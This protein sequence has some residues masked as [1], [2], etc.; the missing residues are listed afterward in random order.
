MPLPSPYVYP[1]FPLQETIINPLDGAPLAGGSVGFYSDPQFTILKPIYQQTQTPNGPTYSVLQNPLTLDGIGSYQDESGTEIIPF[2][3]P[4]SEGTPSD[5]TPQGEVELYF[6]QVL[7]SSGSLVF[8]RENWPPN[9]PNFASATSTETPQSQNLLVNSQFSEVLFPTS[10]PYAFSLSGTNT[11]TQIAPGWALKT[12]GAGTVTVSQNAL[13]LQTPSGAP[14]SLTLNVGSGITSIT[15]FQRVY[16]SPRLANAAYLAG[17]FEAASNSGSLVPLSFNYI[18]SSTSSTQVSIIPSMSTASDGSYGVFVDGSNVLSTPNNPDAPNGF[19]SGYVDFSITIPAL[20]NISITSVQVLSV[21]SESEMVRFIQMS[22]PQQAAQLFGYWQPALNYKPIRSYLTGWDFPLNPAQSVNT[23]NTPPTVGPTTLGG[24]NLSYYVWDQTILFQSVDNMLVVSRNAQTNGIK[25]TGGATTSTCALIQYLPSS[26][27]REI[28]SQRLS[29]QIQG[30]CTNTGTTLTGTVSMYWTTNSTLPLLTSNYSLVSS[31][32]TTTAIPVVGGGGNYGDWTI[33]P[34]SGLGNAPSFQL[35]AGVEEF[36][37]SNWDATATNASTTATY[38]AIV[39]AFD[40]LIT[41]NNVTLNYVSLVPG[42]IATRPAPQTSDEV[43]RECEHYY[44]TSYNLSSALGSA[45][46][47]GAISTPQVV[48]I[49][50][51][52]VTLVISSFTT[53]FQPKISTPNITYYAPGTVN[54]AGFVQGYV[55]TN[56]NITFGNIGVSGTWV[57]NSGHR[58]NGMQPAANITASS[59]LIGGAVGSAS[60]NYHFVSD[61]R[62][63]IV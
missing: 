31:V 51:G 44:E 37:F 34:R 47:V 46:N 56:T 18:P 49:S 8:T 55:N 20:A 48:N 63:G 4:Y 25:I 2:L 7:D 53:Y 21:S 33:V 22:V 27:A 17:Y 23:T 24:V 3:Y 12:N 45:T 59:V 60:V 50:G 16:M 11:I 52:N 19:V 10:A 62:L 43:L 36:S 6:I 38:M 58:A 1:L 57:A 40:T 35:N 30:F 39:V 29:V 42:D 28:L 54:A 5:A 9:Q 15:L 26:I 14:Y 32:A 41:P 61:A 13:T